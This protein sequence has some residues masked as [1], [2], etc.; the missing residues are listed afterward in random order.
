MVRN[1]VWVGAWVEMLVEAFEVEDPSLEIMCKIF[2]WQTK[3]WLNL[4]YHLTL[5]SLEKKIKEVV[6]GFLFNSS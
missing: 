3:S 1:S 2:C 6:L 4:S 5:N